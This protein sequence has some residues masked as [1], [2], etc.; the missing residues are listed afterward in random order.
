[1][2]C[3]L[4]TNKTDK[5]DMILSANH[6]L[7]DGLRLRFFA[8]EEV[9]NPIQTKPAN[10]SEAEPTTFPTAEPSDC[11][12]PDH[13]YNQARHVVFFVFFFAHKKVS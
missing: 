4:K 5:N 8:L 7:R 3:L 13:R 1:L 9:Y 2:F 6:A 11:N 10:S 12:A